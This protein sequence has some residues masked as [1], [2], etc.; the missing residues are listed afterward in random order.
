MQWISSRSREN[1]TAHRAHRKPWTTRRHNSADSAHTETSLDRTAAMAATERC[2]DRE[3]ELSDP[4]SLSQHGMA[5]PS[6]RQHAHL[7]S[8][9]GYAYWMQGSSQ[10]AQRT[11][12]R[13]AGAWDGI[14][15]TAHNAQ[16]AMHSTHCTAHGTSWR[17]SQHQRSRRA[18]RSAVEEA[19]WRRQ[20]A[21]AWWRRSSAP[22]PLAIKGDPPELASAAPSPTPP[23]SCTAIAHATQRQVSAAP[24]VAQ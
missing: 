5:P 2:T 3:R 24:R 11:C 18:R 20:S 15:S 8:R 4:Q 7:H 16:Y 14:A 10:L 9:W 17:E 6:T 19:W 12:T 1:A 21:G 22:M 23:P 13:A